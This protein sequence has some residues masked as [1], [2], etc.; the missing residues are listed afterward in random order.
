MLSEVLIFSDLTSKIAGEVYRS[1]AVEAC[2]HMRNYIGL[3][4]YFFDMLTATG[5]NTVLKR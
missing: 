5:G 1:P 3:V 4:Q 2:A